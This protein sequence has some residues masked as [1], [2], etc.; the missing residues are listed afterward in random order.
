[1]NSEYILDQIDFG[2]IVVNKK[3]MKIVKINESARKMLSL[4][5]ADENF[6]VVAYIQKKFRVN[7][8][9]N[10]YFNFEGETSDTFNRI[11]EVYTKFIDGSNADEIDTIVAIIR[12]ITAIKSREIERRNSLGLIVNKL[13]VKIAEAKTSLDRD[14]Y[15]K[16]NQLI[17][18]LLSLVESSR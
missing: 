6:D 2:V 3:T 17:K 1:M 9:D 5:N 13:K 11:F 10:G 12:D 16:L 15:E 7:V 8:S 18:E 14:C 4:S